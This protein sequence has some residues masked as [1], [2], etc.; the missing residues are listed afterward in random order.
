MAQELKGLALLSVH[1][2]GGE[3]HRLEVDA[4]GC[5]LHPHAGVGEGGCIDGGLPLE[6]HEHPEEG[7]RVLDIDAPALEV[8]PELVGLHQGSELR[9]PQTLH[10]LG[11]CLALEE[12]RQH[13]P[14][15]G[16][17]QLMLHD[18]H[19][20]VRQ[21]QLQGLLHEDAGDD[22]PNGD[23][24][25]GH[26][27]QEGAGQHESGVG[28]SLV[29]LVPVHAGSRGLEECH[30]RGEHRA[31][32]GH[33]LADVCV[34][35]THFGEMRHDALLQKQRKDVHHKDQ[36]DDAPHDVHQGAQH[37][38][39]HQA[40]LTEELQRAKDPEDLHDP[41]QAHQAQEGEVHPAAG[42]LRGSIVEDEEVQEVLED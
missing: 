21:R 17:L 12:L 30:H 20:G 23:E 4:G 14:I 29:R 42:G 8:R 32:V 18:H 9:Q 25:E 16:I 6:L 13:L 33:H 34:R 3:H 19:V 39:Q 7:L 37:A 1:Q 5:A 35:V 38:I 24:D 40:E 27:C 31:E 2:V 15:L 22:V 41:A 11:P 36:H 10:A 26:V 28:E